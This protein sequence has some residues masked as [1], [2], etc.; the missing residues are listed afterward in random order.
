VC[1][2]RCLVKGPG[3]ISVDY[4]IVHYGAMGAPGVPH[5]LGTRAELQHIRA[6]INSVAETREEK[7]VAAGRGFRT[8]QKIRRRIV[9]NFRWKDLRHTFASWLRRQGVELGTIGALLGHR[10][11]SR[12]TS[13]YAH[14]TAD[15]KHAAVQRLAGLLPGPEN[16]SGWPTE[17][18]AEIRPDMN[19]VTASNSL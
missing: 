6:G 13:R 5:H 7:R 17:I 8:V 11:G 18:C 9:H 16:G 4:A 3:K 12:M 10:E 14:L 2:G 19:H 1:Q 15:Q